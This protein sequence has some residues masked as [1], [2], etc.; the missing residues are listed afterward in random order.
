M[1]SRSCIP[2]KIVGDAVLEGD[3]PAL[4]QG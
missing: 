3:T 1:N 2:S 4:L